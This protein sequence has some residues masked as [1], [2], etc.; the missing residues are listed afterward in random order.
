M[1]GKEGTP[2]ALRF[3]WAHCQVNRG[4]LTLWKGPR[5][6][7][8]EPGADRTY[9]KSAGN[10]NCI[11]VND[12]DQ[13]G[14]GQVWHPRLGLNQVG[15]IAF[16]A[17]G[18]LVSVARA[19]LQDAYPPE[20]R[21]KALSRVLVHLKPDHF[22]VFDRL[23][24]EGR[25]KGEWR[26]HAAFVEPLAPSDGFTA[27]GFQRGRGRATAFDAAFIRLPDVSCQV[28]FLTPGV[29]AEFGMSDVYFRGDPFRQPTRRLR[30]IREGDGPLT[31]LTA[32]APKLLLEAKGKGVYAARVGEVSWTVLVGGGAADG[33]SSD[34]HLA[35]AA[36]DA[37][38]QTTEALRFG[39][40]R[41]EYR[42]A[43]VPGG[44]EDAFGV[45]RNGKLD[46]ALPG[47]A[48]SNTIR[49]N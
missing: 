5:P 45:I 43:A 13:W 35:I 32:F 4:S 41:L 22:L 2:K 44:A 24:T 15:R 19:D 28:A 26:F 21:I 34:A 3:N 37:R 39:G 36:H 47:S 1:F 17:D 9:R 29:K 23:E 18:S 46:R 30:V 31:L 38:P 40:T 7:I 27:F 16:F 11:L 33:L 25:G 14:G 48:H 10:D 49:P 42:G 12:T 8:V 6:I 20:A